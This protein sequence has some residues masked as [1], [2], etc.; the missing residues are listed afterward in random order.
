MTAD[1]ARATFAEC[2]QR[3]DRD[4]QELLD[5]GGEPSIALRDWALESGAALRGALDAAVLDDADGE[6]TALLRQLE[7]LVGATYAGWATARADIG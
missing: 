6:I 2:S 4:V 5:R 7:V 1:Q 3:W